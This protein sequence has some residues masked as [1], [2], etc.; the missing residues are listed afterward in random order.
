MMAMVVIIIGGAVSSE[1]ENHGDGVEECDQRCDDN[2]VF[3][4]T[5]WVFLEIAIGK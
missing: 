4:T 2:A 1:R 5:S 3:A